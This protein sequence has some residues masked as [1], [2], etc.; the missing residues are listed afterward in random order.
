MKRKLLAYTT[1]FIIATPIISTV[2]CH[3]NNKPTETI[4]HKSVIDSFSI[5]LIDKAKLLSYWDKK[6]F[7]LKDTLPKNYSWKIKNIETDTSLPRYLCRKAKVN[8]ELLYKNKACGKK[9]WFW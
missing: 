4:D 7:K 2:S 9:F 1:P 8:V 5:S 6:N 3:N